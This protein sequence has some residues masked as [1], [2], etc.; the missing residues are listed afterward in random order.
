MST[1]ANQNRS[2]TKIQ[3]AARMFL[4]KVFVIQEYEQDLRLLEEIMREQRA[5]AAPPPGLQLTAEAVI[6][7]LFPEDL[8]DEGV[9]DV[10]MFFEGAP[11]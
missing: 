8:I 11:E 1:I 2:A 7:A 10:R 6:R 5:P 3:A 9:N 4:A